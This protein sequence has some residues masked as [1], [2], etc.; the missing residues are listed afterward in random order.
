[1]SVYLYPCL[2][3]HSMVFH[4]YVPESYYPIVL[5][6]VRL[7]LCCKNSESFLSHLEVNVIRENSENITIKGKTCPKPIRSFAQV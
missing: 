4:V 7:S 3:T 2:P 1:M 5:L 6:A